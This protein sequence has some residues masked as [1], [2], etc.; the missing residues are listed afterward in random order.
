MALSKG[1]LPIV[2]RYT[3][4]VAK[5]DAF[6]ARVAARHGDDMQCGSG[7]SDC[8]E[9]RL[10]ITAVEAQA[11]ASALA[12]WPALRREALAANARGATSQ[13]CAALDPGGRCLIYEVRPLACRSHGAPIRMHERS[14]PVIESCFRNFTRV[15]PDADCVLDQT[16]LSALVLAVDRDAGGDGTRVDLAGLLL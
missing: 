16:T 9:V 4:L 11:I 15:T 7:C 2:S 3:E 13:R 14:L 8:C 12:A 5:V 6:F 10:T 1:T